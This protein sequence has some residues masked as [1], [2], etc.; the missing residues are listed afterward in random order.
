MAYTLYRIALISVIAGSLKLI[1]YL[2]LLVQIPLLLR[3]TDIS[4]YVMCHH[5]MRKY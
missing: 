1:C 5:Q 3:L 4:S 2:L